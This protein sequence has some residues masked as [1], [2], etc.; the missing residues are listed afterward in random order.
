MDTSSSRA[1]RHLKL[2]ALYLEPRNSHI[3]NRLYIDPCSSNPLVRATIAYQLSA[4]AQTEL[5]KALT[6]NDVREL[7]LEADNAFAALST[8][9]GEAT[10]F[11]GAKEPSLF[12]ASVFAY[13]HLLLNQDIGWTHD[14]ELVRSVR[15]R[16]N[17]VK[18]RNEVLRTYYNGEGI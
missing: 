9:L 17:L 2:R 7:Y 18:H 15:R 5:L 12:D 11:F 1:N 14:E 3:R 13:T 16:D 4:A 6:L 8:L 10:W